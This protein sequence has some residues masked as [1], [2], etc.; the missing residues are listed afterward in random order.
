MLWVST[1]N[2]MFPFL[3]VI[4]NVTKIEGE[5]KEILVKSRDGWYFLL[6]YCLTSSGGFL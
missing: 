2:S 5:G 3:S 4:R 1:F 6:I